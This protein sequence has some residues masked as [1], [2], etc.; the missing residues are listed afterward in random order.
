M[1]IDENVLEAFS[2]V[3]PYLNNFFEENVAFAITDR[4]KYLGLLLNEEL[5]MK[6]VVGDLVPQGGA[7][8]DA[9]K[10]GKV[11]IKDVP[12]E[13]YDVAFKSYAVPIKNSSSDVIGC[14]VAGKSMERRLE[15]IE[16]SKNLANSLGEISLAVQ[17]MLTKSQQLSI[18]NG[19]MIL[20]AKKASETTKETDNIV[21]FV[22]NISSQTNL[23]G[24]NAAIEASRAGEAGKGFS[25]V[26]QEIRKLSNSTTESI[27]KID[28]V[29]KEIGKTVSNISNGVEESNSFYEEQSSFF[30]EIT[31]SIEELNSNAMILNKLATEI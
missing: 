1:D 30:E 18:T 14:V 2:I 3:L 7:I 31:A 21:K 25:V 24:L 20:E 5:P 27:K 13:I 15:V 19:T 8:F 10:T 16:F 29:L 4:E 17:N 26:A 12:K 28:S 23:L 11:I 22:K 6:A 9:I